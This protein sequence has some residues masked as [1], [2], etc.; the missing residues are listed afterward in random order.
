MNSHTLN[1]STRARTLRLALLLAAGV[2]LVAFVIAACAPAAAPVPTASPPTA[3]PAQPTAMPQATTAPAQPTSAPSGGN[4]SNKKVGLSSP[5]EVEILNEF[6]ADMKKEASLP[7]NQITLNIV[8]A[9]G[10]A[11]KQ[12]ADLEAFLAQ[13]YDGIFFLALAPGGLDDFVARATAKGVCVFNH[14][15]SPV[16]GTT[17]NVVLD[18]HAS[19]YEVGKYAAKWINDRGGKLEVAYLSNKEDPQLQLRSQGEKDAIKELAP[20]AVVVGEVEANTIEKGAAGAANLLQAHPNISV[21]LAFS[22]D[23]GLGAYQAATEAGKKDPNTFFIGSLDGTNLVFD[24]IQEGG[25]Y[26]ATWSYLFPFSAVQWMRDMEKCLRGE[27]VPPTRTEFGRL[28]TKDNLAE[29]RKMVADPLAPDVQKFYS[30]PAVMKY[31]DT[32]LTTPK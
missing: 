16:T 8:D 7:E 4:L 12:S 13:G 31:S 1:G 3:A 32:P 18:Q 24:K 23:G 25:I 19:G 17:Q 15:A 27:K 29:V 22:D 9:K 14:S 10:D 2:L 28:V 20:N 21:I 11:V 5:I 26:Q 6:Y 30:D